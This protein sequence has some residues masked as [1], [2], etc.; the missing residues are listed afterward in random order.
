MYLKAVPMK[1]TSSILLTEWQFC[2]S[3]LNSCQKQVGT[4]MELDN[5]YA[6]EGLNQSNVTPLLVS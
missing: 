3:K 4:V 6:S 1:L 2:L 5:H